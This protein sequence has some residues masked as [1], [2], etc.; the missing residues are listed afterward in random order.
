MASFS[1]KRAVVSAAKKCSL[2]ELL[3]NYGFYLAILGI[4]ASFAI[5]DENFLTPGNLFNVVTQADYLIVVS[6]GVMLTI[7]TTGIDLSVGAVLA[8]SAVLGAS[9]MQR[10]QSIPLG[11]LVM[12]LVGALCGLINGLV[13]VKLSF[14]PFIATLAMMN[15]SRGI[16]L[17][18]T[19]G[20]SIGGLPA[21]YRTIGWGKLAGVP[22]TFVISLL[23]FF[24]GWFLL[25]CTNYGRRL[26]AVGGS[27]SAAQVMGISVAGTIVL[28][29]VMSGLLAGVGGV[30]MS[31]RLSAARS[32]MAD[33]LQMDA[34]AAVVIGGTSL[35]G[36][37]G[38]IL[39]TLV[40]ALLIAIIRNGLN[41]LGVEYY[42]QIVL[43][44]TI[45]LAAAAIDSVKRVREG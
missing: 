5:Q 21:G 44:G 18:L 4:I 20:E 41:L 36:G 40:G 26:Y 3:L 24:V 7:L 34:I 45:I 14:P 23:L 11:I 25:K 13:T 10:T 17:A 2:T 35:D 27:R 32:I 9:V 19:R 6:I 43:T 42:Y 8:M 30:L 1:A 16:S 38:S 39:G 28:A 31:A 12:L 33:N 37:K 29:Y 22:I 15:L